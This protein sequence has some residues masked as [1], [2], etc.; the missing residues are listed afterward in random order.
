MNK[1]RIREIAEISIVA[2]LYAV[3]T[4]ALTPLSYGDVQFRI[5]EVLMLLIVYKK[6]YSISMIIGCLVANLFSPV[7]WADIVFGTLATAISCIPMMFIKNLEVSSL[8]PSI[9]NGIIVGLELSIVYDL[10]IPITMFTVFLGEF[11]VVSL[12]GIPL[13]R[14]LEKNEGFTKTLD[15]EPIKSRFNIN[16]IIYLTIANFVITAIFF[17]K[18]SLFDI[19]ESDNTIYH[20]LFYNVRHNTSIL[21]SIIL[22][23]IPF[24]FLLNPFKNII[25]LIINII[26]ILGF[27]IDFVFVCTK[28]DVNPQ[29]SFYL[30][31]IVPIFMAIITMLKF[32]W[33]KD[34]SNIGNEVEEN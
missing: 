20:T 13:F 11:V 33:N 26:C 28:S 14:S 25:G 24:L 27:V 21:I 15:I 18:L 19:T 32:K 1:L 9:F 2:A 5:S 3:L 16:P 22:L 8:F 29:A 23:I 17:F 31:I 12:L 30:F 7:G 34:L 4:L 10:P 6:R